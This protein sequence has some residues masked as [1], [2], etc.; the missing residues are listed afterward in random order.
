MLSRQ[1]SSC[2][3]CYLVLSPENFNEYYSYNQRN[4][5]RNTDEYNNASN[6]IGSGRSTGLSDQQIHQPISADARL[7]SHVN[8]CAVLT[9]SKFF[10]KLIYAVYVCSAEYLHLL[11]SDPF[12]SANVAWTQAE[13]G[14]VEPAK[15]IT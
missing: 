7:R 12:E 15:E 5:R 2:C 14:I 6:S 9:C 1:G 10:P 8:K 13:Q 11:V 3:C 4:K